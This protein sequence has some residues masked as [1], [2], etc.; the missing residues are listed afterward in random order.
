MEEEIWKPIKGYE[1]KY[2]I[3]SHGRLLSKNYKITKK[4]KLLKLVLNKH[5]YFQAIL[6]ASGVYKIV[7]VHRLVA[8]TFIPNPENKPQVDHI[9]TIRTDNRVENLRWVTNLENSYNKYT[10][11]KTRE[12]GKR[13]IK[14]AIEK[15]KRKVICVE[16]GVVYNSTKEAADYINVHIASLTRPLK[17]PNR[18]A[19]GFHWIYYNG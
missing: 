17:Y 19:G 4:N 15:T 13:T 9:N 14:F 7:R 18:T 16:T 11:K 2:L 12:N 1:N 6:Y 3:S 8:E 10:I 5:G